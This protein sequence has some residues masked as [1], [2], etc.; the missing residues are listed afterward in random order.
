MIVVENGQEEAADGRQELPRQG[1]RLG[2]ENGHAE[3]GCNKNGRGG[4]P[5]GGQRMGEER[6][7]IVVFL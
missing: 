5:Q 2:E 6:K 4:W 1:Q 3:D 7:E